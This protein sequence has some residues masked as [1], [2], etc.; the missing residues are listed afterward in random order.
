M[1]WIVLGSGTL[2]FHPER[3][4]SAH[5]LVGDE[6]DALLVDSGPGAIDRL[7]RAG[8]DPRALLGVAH[9]HLHLDHL[10]DLFPLLFERV[11]AR[12]VEPWTLAGGPG[13]R[14]RL[15]A[16]FAALYPRLSEL[17]L[18][19]VE[20]PA[21]GVPRALPGTPWRLA[22][23]PAAHSQNAHILRLDGAPSGEAWSVAYSGDTGPCDAL[24]AAAR[25]VDQL[26]IECT[27]PDEAPRV[28]HL[29]P[30]DVAKVIAEARPRG[31]GLVHLAPD[32]RQPGDAAD[33]VRR[34][35]V[36]LGSDEA[37]V[38]IAGCRDGQELRL[39]TS[40]A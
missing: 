17:P 19:W 29:T 25:D 9:S 21:D 39:G 13:H 27:T 40:R 33:A 4:C 30:R 2:E 26:V 24:T 37:G 5:A 12:R 11:A 36:A 20:H 34:H 8:L 14:A 28:G 15:D 3:G 10:A 23:W 31:V 16:V 22:L 7:L 32:W 1:R 38:P 18:R 6:G 35:L